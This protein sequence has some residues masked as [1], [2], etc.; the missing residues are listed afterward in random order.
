MIEPRTPM[1]LSTVNVLGP[2]KMCLFFV[3]V[4]IAT[5]DTK[6]T[7]SSFLRDVYI[8]STCLPEANN[9]LKAECLK[10]HF[11]GQICLIYSRR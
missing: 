3:S 11:F 8:D 1:L 10:V 5:E 4:V 9:I 7:V 2:P 6:T